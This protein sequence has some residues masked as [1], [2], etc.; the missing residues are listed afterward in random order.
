MKPIQPDLFA[1]TRSD[2]PDTSRE[3]AAYIHPHLT[4]LQYKV[5]DWAKLQRSFTDKEMVS[6]L[7]YL[8]G[9]AE[10]TWRTRRSELRDC[11][12]IEPIGTT[13]DGKGK[14]HTVWRIKP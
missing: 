13:T 12:M 14:R 1:L 6:S 2:D 11:G 3:A 7:Q 10:S 8:H 5:L 4:A 9:G